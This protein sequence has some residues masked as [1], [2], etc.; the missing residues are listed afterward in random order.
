LKKRIL[1]SLENPNFCQRLRAR[2]A[3]DGTATGEAKR[4]LFLKKRSKKTL[5]PSTALVESRTSTGK[6]LFCFFFSKKKA[7]ASPLCGNSSQR[8]KL[9]NFYPSVLH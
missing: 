9:K 5:P 6:K 8:R 1:R 7:L 4:L 2:K 3:A